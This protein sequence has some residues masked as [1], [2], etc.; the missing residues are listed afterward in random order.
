M[1]NIWL[2]A[3]NELSGSIYGLDG[4]LPMADRE[5]AK[6]I[7]DS[8]IR[9]RARYPA[10]HDARG[11]SAFPSFRI[12]SQATVEHLLDIGKSPDDIVT[13]ISTPESWKC[14]SM[15]ANT[16]N[17]AIEQA[18]NVRNKQ[19]NASKAMGVTNVPCLPALIG[20][21]KQIAW[22]HAIRIVHAAKAPNSKHLQDQ[23]RASWWIDNRLSL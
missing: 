7:F 16:P 13:N 21:S 4:L 1:P 3:S 14:G 5:I 20:S 10:V 17:A 18:A 12:C 15:R 2:L 19:A 8:A 23:T 9:L 22:A 6:K 11:L